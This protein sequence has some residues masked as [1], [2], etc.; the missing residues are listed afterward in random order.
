MKIKR[1]SQSQKDSKK[2]EIVILSEDKMADSEPLTI[3]TPVAEY[4]KK[5]PS[6]KPT[7]QISTTTSTVS[8]HIY[9]KKYNVFGVWRT[10]KVH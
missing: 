1:S 6:W 9:T 8:D 3:P 4:H 5:R 10:R 2:K 7:V